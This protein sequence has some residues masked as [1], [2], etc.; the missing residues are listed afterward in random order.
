[1]HQF[2]VMAGIAA[3][4]ILPGCSTGE[5]VHPEKPKDEFMTDYKA[6]QMRVQNDP[7]LQQGS[8]F[9]EVTVIENCVKK[10][11]WVYYVPE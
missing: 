2:I 8:K 1:M 3:G 7:K 10:M 11:G 9:I 4:L 6:C 5:W